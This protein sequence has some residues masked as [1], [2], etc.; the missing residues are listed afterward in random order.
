MPCIRAELKDRVG[1]YL[2]SDSLF[3]LAEGTELRRK[4][5]VDALRGGGSL[6]FSGANALEVAG[7][8]GESAKK[9]SAF[10]DSLGHYWV[11]LELSPWTVVR[12]EESGSKRQSPVSEWFM[13]AY[14]TERSFDLS[15]QG[16]NA[17]DCSASTFFR[18][19]AVLDWVHD[20]RDKVRGYAVELDRAFGDE[21]KRLRLEYQK[22][23]SAVDRLLPVIPFDPCC[24][25]K[26][27]SVH[28]QRRFAKGSLQFKKNDSLDF[29]HAV[30]ASAY[31]NIATLDTKWRQSVEG[32]PRP[33]R[34]AKMYSRPTVGELVDE[35][36]SLV[37]RVKKD[38]GFEQG[39]F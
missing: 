25:A 15:Q 32:L 12:R 18:L 23:P 8:L 1:V 7:P 31:G 10:L 16:D 36:E 5:F 34:L 13:R 19:S 28:L 24:P 39:V 11:P 9:L 17:F 14:F 37:T 3:E 35:L 6:L 30:T 38:T 33:N 2:D 20:Q 29:C 26:F 21:W 27:V 4:R 22:D